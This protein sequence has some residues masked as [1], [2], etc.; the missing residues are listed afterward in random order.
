MQRNEPDSK[1]PKFSVG[2]KL[3]PAQ[4][5]VASIALF[6][7]LG[8]TCLQ[9]VKSNEI[10]SIELGRLY[11]SDKTK[12]L[13]LLHYPGKDSDDKEKDMTTTALRIIK[14]T[15]EQAV[16]TQFPEFNFENIIQIYTVC[17]VN[18]Y[19]LIKVDHFI[20]ALYHNRVLTTIDSISRDYDLDYVKDLFPGAAHNQI[21][22]GW[23]SM[24]LDKWQCG[25]YVLQALRI[26]LT[27][28]SLPDKLVITKKMVAE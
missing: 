26:N 25:H 28:E 20:F 16:R 19:F 4:V 9:V 3:V 10:G 13:Y 18:T 5:Y 27:S 11:Q 2:K 23:Q 12:K 15:N 21:K 8:F 17:E 6:Q 14:K 7:S 24:L 1:A 22:T